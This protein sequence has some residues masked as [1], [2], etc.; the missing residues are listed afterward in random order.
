MEFERQRRVAHDEVYASALIQA[1]DS[2]I[3]DLFEKLLASNERVTSAAEGKRLLE[4]DDDLEQLTDRIQR[5]VG[6]ATPV[7]RTVA[8]GARFTRVP[9]VLVAS[10]AVSAATTVRAGLHEL[11]ILAS[12]VAY[13]LEQATGAP[14]DP[15]LVKKLALELYLKPRRAPD[16]SQ[17]R[18]P[19][20]RLVRHWLVR[21][22]LGRDTRKA[23]AKSLEAA[24]RLDLERILR[25]A[26][27]A[28]HSS[29]TAG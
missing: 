10:T 1:A 3:D 14:P 7:L 20:V 21:G 19:L 27:R 6:L 4:A 22:A 23:A 8:R 5:F 28:A 24:E 2:L 9:W 18:L 13:R 25:V 29:K 12:F 16:V 26:P 17:L 15:R 11:R